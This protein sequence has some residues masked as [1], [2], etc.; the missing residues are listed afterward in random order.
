MAYILHDSG[1]IMSKKEAACHMV[2]NSMD[3]KKEQPNSTNLRD[4]DIH[5]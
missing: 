2:L 5:R 1:L 4:H 3:R